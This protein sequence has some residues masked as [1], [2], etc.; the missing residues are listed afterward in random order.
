MWNKI[1]S[2][3]FVEEVP[4]NTDVAVKPLVH[5]AAPVNSQ[6]LPP[7]SSV[8]PND[9]VQVMMKTI[10]DATMV[11]NTTQSGDQLI[12]WTLILLSGQRIRQQ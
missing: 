4:P 1:K 6:M 3:I 9:K 12:H 8:A 5:A 7:P 2:A 11:R 10:R